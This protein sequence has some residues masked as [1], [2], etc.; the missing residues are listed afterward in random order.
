MSSGGIVVAPIVAALSLGAWLF[1]YRRYRA[2]ADIPT[3]NI[4]SAVQGYVELQGRA[5]A[6]PSAPLFS[7][8]RGL[9]CVWYRYVVQERD[10][11]AW[12]TIQQ[13]TS[14]STFLLRDATGECIIDPDHAEILTTHRK[15]KRVGEQ[16]FTEYLLLAKDPL[17]A[18]GEFKTLNPVDTRL[19]VREDLGTLL[20][21][22]KRD[23]V[24]LLKKFDLDKNGEIDE[25]EWQ[26]ARAQAKR[27]VEK[28]HREMRA[29][30]GFHVLAASGNGRH[31]LIT[32]R[33]PEIVSQSLLRWSWVFLAAFVVALGY[34]GYLLNHFP[35]SR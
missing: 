21:E 28:Q 33:D 18:L 31:F 25:R 35:H 24:T 1:S 16:R 19:D 23:K 13:E 22:W 14:D 34:L 12:K 29:Q 15:V 5:E 32:N 7:R 9:P 8:L 6:H 20:A 11:D 17:Y 2:V 3:S 26:L 27:D 30:P 10:A 4:A